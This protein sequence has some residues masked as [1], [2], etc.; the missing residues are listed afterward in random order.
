MSA[1]VIVFAIF[2]VCVV[3]GAIWLQLYGPEPIVDEGERKALAALGRA[4]KPS[5]PARW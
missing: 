2:M 3:V 5:V 4:T 1:G